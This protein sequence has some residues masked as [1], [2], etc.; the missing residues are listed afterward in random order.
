M[1]RVAVA[2][3]RLQDGRILKNQVV[4]TAGSDDKTVTRFYPLGEELP[5]TEWHDADYRISEEGELMKD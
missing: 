2:R 5:F 4:E 1:K 3:L